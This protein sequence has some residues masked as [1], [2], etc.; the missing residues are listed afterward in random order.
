MKLLLLYCVVR[1]EQG[2]S[3]KLLLMFLISKYSDI[4]FLG[5]AV[6]VHIRKISTAEPCLSFLYVLEYVSYCLLPIFVLK[7]RAYMRIC[8]IMA[9]RPLLRVGERCSF[10]PMAST[11]YGSLASMSSGVCPE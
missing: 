11:K 5:G 6:P 9:T 8:F 4:C 10:S 2:L 7:A 1:D 3:K